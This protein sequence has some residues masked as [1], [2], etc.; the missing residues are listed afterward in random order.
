MIV[1][2]EHTES[3]FALVGI[4]IIGRFYPVKVLGLFEGAMLKHGELFSTLIAA[5]AGMSGAIISIIVQGLAQHLEW[6]LFNRLVKEVSLSLLNGVIYV[7]LFVGSHLLTSKWSLGNRHHCI[8]F[9]NYNCV[10]HRN[11]CTLVI[12]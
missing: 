3:T 4:S 8:S 6:S 2:L 9:G 5:M 1:F 7:I 10:A 12:G 11:V